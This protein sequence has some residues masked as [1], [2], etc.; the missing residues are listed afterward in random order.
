MGSLTSS[1]AH[2]KQREVREALINRLHHPHHHPQHPPHHPQHP[3]HHHRLRPSG[4]EQEPSSYEAHATQTLLRCIHDA[5]LFAQRNHRRVHHPSS[6]ANDDDDDDDDVS[7]RFSFI[8]ISSL[9]SLSW[10]LSLSLSHSHTLT[11]S[12][13]NSVEH[14]GPVLFGFARAHRSC[15]CTLD[16]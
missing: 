1:R 9:L 10:L 2:P 3:P 7:G 6:S 11:H 13:T 15:M 4:E 16:G 12:L 5:L 8:F 14:T